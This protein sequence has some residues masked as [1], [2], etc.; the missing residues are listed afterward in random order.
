LKYV[1]NTTSKL[2]L[3]VVLHMCDNCDI[4]QKG[5]EVYVVDCAQG[6][7]WYGISSNNNTHGYFLPA[8]VVKAD[9]V[10]MVCIDFKL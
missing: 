5:D 6:D 1:F 10:I 3:C 2:I 8:H 7:R 9:K 4:L